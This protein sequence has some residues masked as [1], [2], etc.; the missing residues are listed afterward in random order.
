MPQDRA[1]G[2]AGR[3]YGLLM[4]RVIANLLGAEQL[5]VGANEARWQGK[6]VVIKACAIGNASFGITEAMLERLDDALLA[7]EREDGSVVVTSLP[8]DRF[9]ATMRDSRSAGANG[10]VKLV[11]RQFAER[12]GTRVARFSSAEIAAAKAGLET[13]A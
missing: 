9:R 12:E 2:A 11:S 5:K 8:V 10:R 1:S 13:S 6:R 7:A 3:A 4:G